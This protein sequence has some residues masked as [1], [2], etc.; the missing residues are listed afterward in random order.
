MNN[1]ILE[2]HVFKI[3]KNWILGCSILSSGIIVHSYLNSIGNIPLLH[4]KY[5]Y[6]LELQQIEK[7]INLIDKIE[8]LEKMILSC[9]KYYNIIFVMSISGLSYIVSRII[10]KKY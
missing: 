1:S 9:W 8:N 3:S 2:K 5:K 10:N 6:R 7:N 4:M